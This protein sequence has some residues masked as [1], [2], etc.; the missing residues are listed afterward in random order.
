MLWSL[1]TRKI[2]SDWSPFGISDGSH[3]FFCQ[4]CL[5]LMP[6]FGDQAASAGICWCV[7][8]EAV[9]GQVGVVLSCSQ[10]HILPV[11]PASLND[12]HPDHTGIQQLGTPAST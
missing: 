7:V 9:A 3:I 11:S 6:C 5:V 2:G 1:G 10:L 12:V 8:E 4:P